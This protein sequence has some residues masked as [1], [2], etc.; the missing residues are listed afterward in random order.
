MIPITGDML[1]FMFSCFKKCVWNLKPYFFMSCLLKA[2]TP[3]VCP[4][5]H[6][7]I[8]QDSTWSAKSWKMPTLHLQTDSSRDLFSFPLA[9]FLLLR[10]VFS[11]QFVQHCSSGHINYSLC[12]KEQHRHQTPKLPHIFPLVKDRYWLLLKKN[13]L[14]NPEV[15]YKCLKAS[16]GIQLKCT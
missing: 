1:L 3:H 11:S 10:I 16:E 7:H 13:T 6:R 5:D 2:P 8:C 4:S 12:N 15:I 9:F 14:K